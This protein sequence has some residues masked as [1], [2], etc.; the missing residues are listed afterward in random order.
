MENVIQ[1][2]FYL[3]GFNLTKYCP[4]GLNFYNGNADN[5]AQVTALQSE[6]TYWSQAYEVYHNSSN[7]Y[8]LF[9]FYHEHNKQIQSLLKTLAQKLNFS[10]TLSI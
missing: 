10:S 6:S 8:F 5:T 9:Q 7:F 1:Q 4:C 3:V 2:E